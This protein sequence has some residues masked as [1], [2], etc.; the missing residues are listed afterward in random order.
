[1][2]AGQIAGLPSA[3]N[4]KHSGEGSLGHSR[5]TLNWEF[6]EE[7]LVCLHSSSGTAA[8]QTAPPVITAL[9]RTRFIPGAMRAGRC[10]AFLCKLWADRG[11]GGNS[12]RF[13]CLLLFLIY[14]DP[15]VSKRTYLLYRRQPQVSINHILLVYFSTLVVWCTNLDMDS[16]VQ[17]STVPLSNIFF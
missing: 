16:V 10:S 12:S 9:Y 7:L 5:K 3:W 1:M 8:P 6:L 4:C 15:C 2:L 17:N 11:G 14:F 13:K